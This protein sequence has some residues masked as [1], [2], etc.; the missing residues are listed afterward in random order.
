MLLPHWALMGRCR[1]AANGSNAAA[2]CHTGEKLEL[3][4]FTGTLLDPEI[5]V[6][7]HCLLLYFSTCGH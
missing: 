5:Y 4:S 1:C 6:G 3:K 2:A 7:Q